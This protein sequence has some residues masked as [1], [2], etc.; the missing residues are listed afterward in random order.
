MCDDDIYEHCMPKQT[1]SEG[2]QYTEASSSDTSRDNALQLCTCKIASDVLSAVSLRKGYPLAL[3]NTCLVPPLPMCKK[4]MIS[5][6]AN[7]VFAR[8]I[9]DHEVAVTCHA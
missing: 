3:K 8:S 4:F 6:T 5:T 2:N 9:F 7:K 1:V